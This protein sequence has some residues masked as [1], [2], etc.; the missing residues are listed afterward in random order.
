MPPQDEQKLKSFAQ[1]LNKMFLMDKFRKS[2]NI[3]VVKA[4]I[5]DSDKFPKLM[6]FDSD[7]SVEMIN[8][9]RKLIPNSFQIKKVAKNDCVFC[10]NTVDLMELLREFRKMKQK[11]LDT[12]NLGDDDTGRGRGRKRA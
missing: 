7:K 2:I 8:L 11:F 1:A 10:H 9:I 3:K 4:T 12:D 6:D 5:K